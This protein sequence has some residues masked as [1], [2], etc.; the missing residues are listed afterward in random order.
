[1]MASVPLRSI[2]TDRDRLDDFLVSHAAFT[3]FEA[4][5]REC[6][7]RSFIK[8]GISMPGT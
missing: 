8:V 6:D 3:G 1:M 5:F 7:S 4:F 2:L